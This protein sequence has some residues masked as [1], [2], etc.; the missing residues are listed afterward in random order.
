MFLR[1]LSGI[2]PPWGDQF[3]T[4]LREMLAPVIYKPTVWRSICCPMIN[5]VTRSMAVCNAGFESLDKACLTAVAC[6]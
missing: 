5:R 4:V 2:F 3:M 1:G 6:T